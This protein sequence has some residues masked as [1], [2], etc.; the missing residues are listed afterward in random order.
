MTDELKTSIKTAETFLQEQVSKNYGLVILQRLVLMYH[1]D[2]INALIALNNDLAVED[3]GSRQYWAKRK[4][5]P[6]VGGPE[7]IVGIGYRNW[8][9]AVQGKEHHGSQMCSVKLVTNL[10]IPGSPGPENR[11]WFEDVR[12]LLDGSKLTLNQQK[13]FLDPIA[14]NLFADDGRTRT[15]VL[16]SFMPVQ[17]APDV[18]SNYKVAE[19]SKLVSNIVLFCRTVLKNQANLPHAMSKLQDAID[20]AEQRAKEFNSRKKKK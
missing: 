11:R 9:A 2:P 17:G 1:A 5:K 20:D 14:W 3:V 7:P 8:K 19:L 10:S 15:T 16:A 12:K 4:L 13:E 18:L 6:I